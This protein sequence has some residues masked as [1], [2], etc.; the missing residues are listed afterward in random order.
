M[1]PVP[2]R[3]LRQELHL[4]R[5]AWGSPRA[6]HVEPGLLGSLP[7]PLQ[8]VAGLQALGQCGRGCGEREEIGPHCPPGAWHTMGACAMPAALGGLTLVDTSLGGAHSLGDPVCFMSL[9]GDLWTGCLCLRDDLCL[10]VLAVPRGAHTCIHARRSDGGQVSVCACVSA[11]GATHVPGAVWA[12]L[13]VHM[14]L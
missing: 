13:Q 10:G 2:L 6:P 3:F 5:L 9:R 12:S 14:G 4:P 1:S 7:N 8:P 11:H